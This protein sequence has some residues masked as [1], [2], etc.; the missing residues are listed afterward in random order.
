MWPGIHSRFKNFIAIAKCMVPITAKLF[1]LQLSRRLLL[2]Q[3]TSK[4]IISQETNFSISIMSLEA[5]RTSSIYFPLFISSHVPLR[6]RDSLE[7][8]DNDRLP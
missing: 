6:N 4:P 5:P 2:Y 1:Y 7:Q 3:E 8:E